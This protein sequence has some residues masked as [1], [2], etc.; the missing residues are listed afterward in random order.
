MKTPIFLIA[1]CLMTTNAPA[2]GQKW[3]PT[4]GDYI[5]SHSH[6]PGGPANT[7]DHDFLRKI[8]AHDMKSKMFFLQEF[9]RDGGSGG[10][11]EDPE[12]AESLSDHDL[13][14]RMHA[15]IYG[16]C[17]PFGPNDMSK[18]EIV[19][20]HTPAGTMRACQVDNYI[21]RDVVGKVKF[22]TTWWTDGLP[23]TGGFGGVAKSLTYDGWACSE[24]VTEVHLKGLTY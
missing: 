24:E 23:L 2:Q 20:I 9:G 16:H 17:A 7:A 22:S 12:N 5:M 13:E 18:Y 6:C 21:F 4:V 15:A 1:L 10:W 3:T 14:G 8:S 11:T 19:E